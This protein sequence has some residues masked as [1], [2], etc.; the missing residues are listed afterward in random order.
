[1]SFI[2]RL[3]SC[4][5][6]LLHANSVL[7]KKVSDRRRSEDQW[8][9]KKSAAVIREDALRDRFLADTVP[10]IIW[11]ARPDG[12]VDYYNKAWFDYTRLTPAESV[13]SGWSAVLHPEDFQPTIDRWT[14]SVATGTIYE[15][16]CRL[17][18]AED[19]AYRWFIV[20]A[21]ARRGEGGEILQWV[22][23]CTDI[24]DQKRAEDELRRTQS[25]LESRVAERVAELAKTNEA[26][27]RQQ[28]EL[29]VLF[30]LMPAMICFKD[31]QNRILRVNRRLAESFGTSVE[32]LEGKSTLEIYP[33]GAAKFYADDL[34]VIHS[35]T[36]R[37]GIIET[38]RDRDGNERWIQT[39]RVPVPDQD[40]QVI[41]IV[42]MVQDIT[43]RKRAEEASRESEERYR[44][45]IEWSPESISVHRGGTLLF[46]NPALVKM[47]GAT[48]A[49]DL[50]GKPII[51]WVHPDFRQ[52]VRDRIKNDAG[53]LPTIEE[54]F[55]KFDGAVI[56]VEVCS[57]SIIY[58]GESALYSSIR[59]VTAR[60]RIEE[61]LRESE[62]RFSDAF[63]YAP[64]GMALASP[65]GRW[66]K[67]NQAFC[68][69][70]G[71]SE[72]GLLTRT[73]QDITP[74]EDTEVS[75]ENA[76][77]FARRRD[78]LLSDGKTLRSRPGTPRHGSLEY[79]PGPRSPGRAALL[80]R[81]YPGH[82][83]AQTHGRG[84]A[85]KARSVSGGHSS[86]RRSALPTSRGKA[87]SCGSMTNCAA[88]SASNA[89][90]CWA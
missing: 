85:G 34:E 41:G 12:G 89:Q 69:L 2:R 6:I 3:F 25:E 55:L 72:A 87:I 62:E 77:R 88:S 13:E 33:S 68:D 59:D 61:A 74:P 53:V 21:A 46:V 39:D 23:S 9:E 78:R 84:I 7:G 45:L 4:A 66:L 83:R 51:D 36:P 47:M 49:Q 37:T 71:Y 16:E 40:G 30:D 14:H 48:S 90:S 86:R 17:K 67:V 56:D 32:A 27:Q 54:K 24:D 81:P 73:F 63:E 22:G 26:L 80:Y 28:T 11:T 29:R 5:G 57:R 58:E 43:E 50:V 20:R 79:F 15:L 42:V 19:G 76:R 31:T 18:R 35:A 75:A 64:I 1:M 60:K 52:I 38:V 44:A 82:H 70:I 10:L 65:A 8:K